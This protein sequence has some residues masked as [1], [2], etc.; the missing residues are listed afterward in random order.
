MARWFA[1]SYF[2][3]GTGKA[4]LSFSFGIVSLP[5]PGCWKLLG[6]IDLKQTSRDDVTHSRLY[7]V[8]GVLNSRFPCNSPLFCIV[9]I[10]FLDQIFDK[11]GPGNDLATIYFFPEQG[12]GIMT[13]LRLVSSIFFVQG[14]AG[15]E[16]IMAEKHN[17]LKRKTNFSTTIALKH[18][19]SS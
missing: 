10:P 16:S 3:S 12:Q 8:P 2:L 15:M 9:F 4:V 13:S 6:P 11:I 14:S 1:F 17:C 18:P 7:G 19:E 5:I